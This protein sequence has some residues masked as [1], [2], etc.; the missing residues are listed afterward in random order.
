MIENLFPNTMMKQNQY[1]YLFHWRIST[2]YVFDI[3][4]VEESPCLIL[5]K[6]FNEQYFQSHW[7]SE[8]LSL[9]ETNDEQSIIKKSLQVGVDFPG[10]R[11]L[12]AEF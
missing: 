3:D 11:F 5:R 1:S 7:N 4:Q 12:I 2:P 6:V 10:E 8:V 9:T